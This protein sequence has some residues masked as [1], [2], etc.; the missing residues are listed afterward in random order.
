L[1]HHIYLIQL[2]WRKK[3]N[4]IKAGDKRSNYISQKFFNVPF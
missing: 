2:Q 1:T 4:N 3:G